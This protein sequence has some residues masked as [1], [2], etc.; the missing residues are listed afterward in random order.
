MKTTLNI[1]VGSTN[2][3]KINAAKSTI[4]T[5]YPDANIHCQGVHAPS[6][7]ADQPMTTSET[8]LGAINRVKY[9]QSHHDADFYFAMEGGVDLFEQ[10]PA[11]FAYLVIATKDTLSV[12]RSASLPLPYQVYQALEQGEELGHVMDRL[13]NTKNIKQQGG[14]IGLLTQQK[15]TRESTY[16]QGLILAMAPLLNPKLFNKD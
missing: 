4:A 7:V 6:L 5:F 13:F 15:A 14:A 2:P 16:T 12:G 10:G 3:I 9:C 8:K 1:I 11:T